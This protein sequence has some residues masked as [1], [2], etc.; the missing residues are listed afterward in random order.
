MDP[1]K[2][3]LN[4]RR[5]IGYPFDY[6][7][8]CSSLVCHLGFFYLNLSTT[9]ADAVTSFWLLESSRHQVRQ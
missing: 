1:T 3:D 2:R 5:V 4:V 6:W 7:L 8:A 9:F